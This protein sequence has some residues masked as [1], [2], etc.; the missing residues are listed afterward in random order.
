M[1]CDIHV[2]FETLQDGKWMPTFGARPDPEEWWDRIAE[3]KIDTGAAELVLPGF[4]E[5][6]GWKEQHEAMKEYFEA[7][8]LDEAEARYG[9][10]PLF[11]RTFSIP[12][13][14]DWSSDGIVR[15]SNR[16]YR[17]FGVVAGVRAPIKGAFKPRGYPDDVSPEVLAEIKRYGDDGH[18]HSW[19]GVQEMLDSD[20]MKE[21]CPYQLSYLRDYIPDPKNTRMVF[22][23]D[24]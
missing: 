16:D 7:I 15:I 21:N 8:P 20:V 23:F 14:D 17:F 24:N 22:Y 18:T 5:L 19:L 4:A 13:A 2:Y 1:G 9:D 12:N 10:H 6:K 11:V 3:N